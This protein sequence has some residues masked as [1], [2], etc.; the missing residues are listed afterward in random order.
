MVTYER[1]RGSEAKEHRRQALLDAAESL[2][3]RDG[4]EAVSMASTAKTAGLSK[5][6]LYLYFPNRE[7]MLL[8]VYARILARTLDQVECLV[9]ADLGLRGKGRLSRALAVHLHA[10]PLLASLL[11]RVPAWIEA[12]DDSVSDSIAASGALAVRRLDALLEARL[13]GLTGHASP[14]RLALA[15]LSASVSMDASGAS[16]GRYTSRFIEALLAGRE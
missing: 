8:Q 1:A 15:A 2:A 16:P 9:R 12:V 11:V 13:P 10:E 4:P 7:A 3:R 5:A 6:A 14:T